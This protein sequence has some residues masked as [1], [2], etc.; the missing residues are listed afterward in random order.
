MN[1]IR[2]F[3]PG[4][5]V[6]K[7]RPVA[8][9]RKLGN[10]KHTVMM[11]TPEKTVNYEAKVALAAEA[12]MAG[13][14]PVEGP[15]VLCLDVHLPVAASW[16]KRD[17]AEALA[18][19]AP[20]TKKPDLDN[21]VKAICDAINGIVWVDDV[22]VVDVVMRKRYREI[23]GVYVEVERYEPPVAAVPQFSLESLATEHMERRA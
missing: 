15:M 20:P 17:K 16:S 13:R 18:D 11:Q 6:G 21:C 19:I 3:V 8:K 12:A 22:Q 10:G 2:F 23:P 5:P 4:L 14:A 7:G 1:V 9:V